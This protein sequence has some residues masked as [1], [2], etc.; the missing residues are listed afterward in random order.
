MINSSDYKSLLSY[1]TELLKKGPVVVENHIEG[2][3]ATISIL[4][5]NA[6]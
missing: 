1:G 3:Q 4:M 6:G 2:R 5:D